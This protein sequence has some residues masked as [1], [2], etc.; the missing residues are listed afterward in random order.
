M[1]DGGWVNHEGGVGLAVASLGLMHFVRCVLRKC[2]FELQM[3]D[4]CCLTSATAGWHHSTAGT[5][6][7]PQV[8]LHMRGAFRVR[9]AST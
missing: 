5:G 3:A 2:T 4:A 1:G 7:L 8:Q 9:F 6:S